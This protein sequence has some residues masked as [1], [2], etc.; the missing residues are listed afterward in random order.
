ML[1]D[2]APSGS[3]K[4]DPKPNVFS[5]TT[6]IKSEST[7]RRRNDTPSL[8]A[9]LTLTLTLGAVLGAGLDDTELVS[10]N[11]LLLAGRAG[12]RK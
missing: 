7:W 12:N 3:V 1:A 4:R 11:V 9:V 10:D 6:S 5:A 8:E 2:C